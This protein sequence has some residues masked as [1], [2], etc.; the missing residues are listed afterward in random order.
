[1]KNSMEIRKGI[2][3]AL[4]AFGFLGLAAQGPEPITLDVAVQKAL[5]ARLEMKA[6]AHRELGTEK[7]LRANQLRYIPQ[8]NAQADLRYNAI[9]ATS[10]VPIGALTGGSSDQTVAVRFGTNWANGAGINLRQTIFDPSIKGTR[11][12]AILNG[13]LLDAQKEQTSEQI[14]V[15]VARAYYALL[16]AEAEVANGLADSALVAQ[17]LR[18]LRLRVGE[19]RAL[20]IDVESAQIDSATAVLR[21]ADIRR[22]AADWQAVLA[23]QMGIGA[24]NGRVLRTATTLA[25]L[26]GDRTW[27]ASAL[28]PAESPAYKIK[29][30]QAEQ[31]LQLQANEKAGF[32]PDLS[33][34]GYLGANH[35]SNT[36]DIWKG[37]KWF[38]TSY[39]GLNLTVPLTEGFIRQQRVERLGITAY[40]D[41]LDREAAKAQTE[42]EFE[43][44]MIGLDG[45][46]DALR[47]QDAVL[48]LSAQ[49]LKLTEMRLAQERATATEVATAR[50]DLQHAQVL[51]LRRVYD[52]LL[53]DLELRRVCGL[54][55]F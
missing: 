17:R 31:T 7:E 52:L 13:K 12:L 24:E 6:L 9:L 25:D 46:E 19:G 18:D 30:L 50:N 42:L 26:L 1:M 35:F 2:F 14:S 43:R 15:D 41:E 54:L 28:A 55:N 22:N 20:P 23:Y 53:A 51:H 40:A 32:K 4:F 27:P 16:I 48:Q 44:A 8:V 37:S 47:S 36:F 33:I 39:I 34:N 10:I 11:E 21:L 38:P 45:A 49:K 29:A 5:A 3:L